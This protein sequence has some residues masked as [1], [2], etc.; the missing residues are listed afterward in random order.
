MK[1]YDEP[2]LKSL[3]DDP[4]IG[5]YT[6]CRHFSEKKSKKSNVFGEYLEVYALIEAFAAANEME[7]EIP[8]LP[9][10][11]EKQIQIIAG[12]IAKIMD[13]LTPYIQSEKDQRLLQNLRREFTI[14]IGK[15]FVYEFSDGDLKKIQNLLNELRELVSKSKIFEE[16]HR[17]R[18]LKRLEKLQSE[19]HKKQSDLDHFWGLVGDAG[20]AVGKF[21]MDAKP[22]V[23]RIREITDIIW[24][25]QSRAVELPSNSKSVFLIESDK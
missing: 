4:K 10:N 8:T 2:F 18:L 12:F 22:F 7:F 19:I 6:I 1:L 24:R 23:D 11:R 9:S 3:D 13:S 5:L 17:R 25:T 14:H 21:G 15:S 20:V 16:K